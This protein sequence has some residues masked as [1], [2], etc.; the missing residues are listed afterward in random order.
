MVMS[1]ELLARI[2]ELEKKIEL[3]YQV[4]INGIYYVGM[5]NYQSRENEA[6]A[7]LHN[8]MNDYETKPQ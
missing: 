6:L 3:V 1:D 8:A 4:G 7:K 5:A 2:A